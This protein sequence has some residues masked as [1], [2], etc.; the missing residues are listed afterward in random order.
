M[1]SG[2]PINR[3]VRR[4]VTHL[5]GALAILLSAGLAEAAHAQ[6]CRVP[7]RL[8]P[9]RV[10]PFSPREVRRIPITDF[11]L[12]VSWSP[13][14]CRTR[15]GRED[16]L[17]CGR[18]AAFDFILHG[19]WPEGEGRN[20]PQYCQPVQALPPEIVRSTFC[21]TPS[22]RLQQHEWAK[23]GSC[24]TQSPA[25]YFKAATTLFNALKWPDMNALS[26][27]QP[28]VGSLAAAIAAANRGMR[29]EM[30]RIVLSRGGWLEEVRIC[31]NRSYRPAA[32]PRDTPG[33]RSRERV[34]I[35][36]RNA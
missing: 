10:E 6:T 23:H 21:A 1:I 3:P 32:C 25:A 14:F 33:A 7:D 26:R 5:A 24:I 27:S 36:R 29:P 15:A 18:G 13:Q 4:A 34:R 2:G 19:L 20:W 31:L 30:I 9:A 8:P 35:W 17:Q 16:Q 22:V 12:A 11:Q 28:D